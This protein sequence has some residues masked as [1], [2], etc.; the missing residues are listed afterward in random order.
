MMSSFA[1]PLAAAAAV[2]TLTATTAQAQTGVGA[3]LTPYA[4]YLVTGNWYDGPLGTSIATTNAP[5]IG[6][7]GAIPLTKGVS[8]VGNLAYAS[9]ELRIGLPLVG[10]VNVGSANTWLYDAGLELGG[11]AGRSTGIAPF[12]QGGIGGMTNDIEAS[13]FQIRASNVAYTAGV[14]VDVGVSEALALRVQAKDWI[15][16]FNTEDAVGFRAEGN[17]AHNWALTAGVKLRF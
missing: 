3:H 13:V 8:L 14:G 4:G 12:V 10:G 1:R 5:M 2:L 6:A 9:G 16:R 15:G 11:L 17:L 7:Q